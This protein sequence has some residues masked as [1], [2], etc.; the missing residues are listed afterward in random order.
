MTGRTKL[1]SEFQILPRARTLCTTWHFVCVCARTVNLW[2]LRLHYHFWAGL[3]FQNTYRSP[4]SFN[5]LGK[6]SCEGSERGRGGSGPLGGFSHPVEPH[7]ASGS[8]RP[9]EDHPGPNLKGT[10]ILEGSTG[11]GVCWP[12][13][14]EAPGCMTRT[15]RYTHPANNW[16][17]KS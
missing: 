17:K 15:A 2:L 7:P 6:S 10:W 16:S 5:S 8:R 9:R 1:C 12:S 13:S 11:F 3:L 4:F 14:K